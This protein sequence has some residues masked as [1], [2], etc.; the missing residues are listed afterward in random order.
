MKKNLNENDDI[1]KSY[2]SA[3]FELFS[4]RFFQK[5]EEA[6]K[7][8]NNFNRHLIMHGNITNYGTE[9]NLYRTIVILD[10]IITVLYIENIDL[11]IFE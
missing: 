8:N 1:A 7:E 3:N 10:F 6:E 5:S 11:E 2:L 9:A 4:K